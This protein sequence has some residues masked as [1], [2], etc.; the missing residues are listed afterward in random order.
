MTHHIHTMTLRLLLGTILAAGAV[1][2]LFSLSAH[3]SNMAQETLP[4]ITFSQANYTA[5]EGGIGT[6]TVSLN[7][8][9]TTEVT[10][11]YRTAESHATPDRDFVPVSAVLTIPA[12]A[13]EQTFEFTPLDDE[14]HEGDENLMLI[15]SEPTNARLGLIDRAVLTIEDDD[16]VDPL[17]IQD[18][19][20]HHR[21]DITTGLALEL[22]EVETDSPLAR[23]KQQGEETVLSGSIQA[24][25]TDPSMTEIF[26]Q[27][28]DWSDYRGISFWYY[29]SDSDERVRVELLG[30][31]GTTTA[32][33]PPQEW[34]LVW[35][36]EFDGTAGTPPDPNIWL[37]EVGDGTL[38]GI[39]GWGNN[40]RQYY[41]RETENAALDGDGNLVVTVKRTDSDDND[42]RCWY[43][44]C[45]YTS[46]RLITR[47][48]QEFEYGRIEA[49]V[50]LPSGSN[51]LWPAFW[52]L[53]T[54]IGEVGWPQSGELDIMEYVSRLPNEIFGTIHG[55]GYSG[56]NA[57]G[58]THI[59]DEPVAASPR[60]FAVEWSPDRI[61]W[62]IDDI[63]YHSATPSDVSP[64]EWVFNHPFFFILNVAIGGNLGGP[65][66]P[67]MVFPQTMRVDYVRVYQ[68]ANNAERY[69]ATF[70]DDFSGWRK[71]RM[72]FSRFTRSSEQ[73][74]GAPD[75]ELSL[76]QIGGYGFYFPES[77]GSFYLDAI[78]LEEKNFFF[79]FI[80]RVKDFFSSDEE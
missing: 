21:F 10:V 29:G 25:A 17:L 62:F 40:E 76:S 43:G 60:T 18:F 24:G 9:A 23:R 12:G 20:G 28:Q 67:K 48:R 80:D 36:D 30:E 58:D 72:P 31:R 71:I 77:A 78:A 49:R 22:V 2:A 27:N 32:D 16:P 61:D 5:P 37:H 38:N 1:L 79:R 26:V 35:S 68:A 70:V 13:Q 8:P 47:H 64:N 19:E 41:T 56:G 3:S 45:E 69:E 55:P 66:H 14:K 15:L 75:D 50:Q 34:T 57:F 39:P 44:A 63:H 52:M 51:G 53:G 6:I 7:S 4:H 54:D 65:I 33:L 42:L 59:F 46:A 73:P 11:H 74:A